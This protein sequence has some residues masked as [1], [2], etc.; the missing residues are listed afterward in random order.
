M[1]EAHLREPIVLLHFFG[2]I[3]VE[4][5]GDD[6]VAEVSRICPR[7]YSVHGVVLVV[8]HPLPD[9]A[10]G[11]LVLVE[12][13]LVGLEHALVEVASLSVVHLFITEGIY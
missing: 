1:V 11:P 5:S 8:A 4:A 3:K 13:V 10:Q 12:V 9:V 7:P 6:L 2:E